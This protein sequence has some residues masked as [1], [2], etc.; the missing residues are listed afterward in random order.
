MDYLVIDGT[1]GEGGGSIL[2]LAAGFS[3]LFNTPIHLQNIRANRDP[4]GLRL[5]HQLGLESLQK[6]SNGKLSSIQVGTTDL[7]FIPGKKI[8]TSLEIPIGTAG[9]IALLSQTLQTGFIHTPTGTPIKITYSGGGTFG[10]GAPDPYYLN[11]VTYQLFLK[12]GFSCHIDVKRN[13]FYPKGGA[14]AV[15]DIYPKQEVSQLTSLNLENK[16]ELLMVGGIIVCSDDLRDSRV[17]ERIQNSI[18]DNLRRNPHYSKLP[19]DAYR[20][21][22]LYDQTRN[23][24]VGLSIWANYEHTVIGSGTVLGERGV[25]SEVVG[26]NTA[27]FLIRETST[28]ATVDTFAADQIIPLLV[29]CPEQSQI[30]VREVTSHLKTNIDLLQSFHP[31][32]IILEKVGGIW[33][34]VYK[35]MK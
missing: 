15:L 35:T 26:K 33:K 31:R 3:V 6:L 1:Q 22:I 10:T 18:V 14:S 19:Y 25:P 20:I 4:P 17:A 28:T 27:N 12:M 9:S 8:S 34:L 23:P 30:L 2:R 24:G 11:N 13:G 5:Q 29:L 32:N 16:G 21:G 7:T